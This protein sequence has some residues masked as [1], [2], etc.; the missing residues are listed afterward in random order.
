[1]SLRLCKQEPV[2]N[3]YYVNF[4]GIHLYSSQ[5]LSY[6]IYHYPLLVMDRLVDDRLLEFLRDDLNMG[7]LALKLDNWRKSGEDPDEM[8]IFLLQEGDYYSQTEITEYR[9]MLTR[10]R[11]QSSTDIRKQRADMYFTMRQY[12]RAAKLYQEILESDDAGNDTFTALVWNNLG[13]CYGRMFLF[14]KAAEAFEK[15]YNRSGN[16]TCLRSIYWISK[17]DDRIPLGERFRNTITDQEREAWENQFEKA[18]ETA[19]HSDQIRQLETCFLDKTGTIPEAARTMIE[20]WKS[21]YRAM[22]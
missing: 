10:L 16:R 3:P 22:V 2:K 20:N 17:L 1:M 13:S 21:E 4:L 15:A 14:D 19:A 5:E 18:R 8:L 11:Q 6:V 7:F 9:Q 12:G